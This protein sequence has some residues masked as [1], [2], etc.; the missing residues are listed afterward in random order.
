MDESRRIWPFA[1]HLLVI[2][3]DHPWT[4]P[5]LAEPEKDPR[6]DAGSLPRF[7]PF[8]LAGEQGRLRVP[9]WPSLPKWR[10][11][12]LRRLQRFGVQHFQLKLAIA[13]L[14]RG[15]R[16]ELQGEDSTAPALG[17]F[18]VDA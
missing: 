11:V 10:V 15:A 5:N 13:H 9:Y 18:K 7:D 12:R 1:S 14:H 8:D 17:I 6:P 16:M 4:Q 2:I 3:Y